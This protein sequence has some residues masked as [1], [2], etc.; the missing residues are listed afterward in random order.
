M[1]AIPLELR[2]VLTVL[3]IAT[4]MTC[5][6]AAAYT[7]ALGRP[8]PRHLPIGVVFRYAVTGDDDRPANPIP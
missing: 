7:V 8:I 2:K 3:T 6:F 5:A 1:E 4:L